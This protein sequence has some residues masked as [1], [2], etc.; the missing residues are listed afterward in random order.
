MNIKIQSQDESLSSADETY[1]R[2]R[3]YFALAANHEDVATAQ[4]SLCAIPGF[5]SEG[6]HHCRVDIALVSGSAVIGDSVG[7]DIYVAIDRAADRSCSQLTSNVDPKWRAFSQ[8]GSMPLR[9]NRRGLA[10]S[11]LDSG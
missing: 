4:V 3:L 8:S 9:D 10:A 11:G 1:I 7:S 2:N 6:M 5:E